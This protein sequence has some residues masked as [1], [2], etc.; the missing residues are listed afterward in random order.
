MFGPSASGKSNLAIRLAQAIDSLRGRLGYPGPGVCQIV[1]CDSVAVYR[2]FDIGSAKPTVIEQQAVPHHLI[3]V[4]EWSQD[5]DAECYRLS[6]YQAMEAI[7]E[8][9]GIPIL[10]G[11]TGL[12]LRAVLGDRFD[13]AVPKNPLLRAQLQACSLKELAERLET[14]NPVRLRQIHANDRVRLMRAI[15][16]ATAPVEERFKEQPRET[17]FPAPSWTIGLELPR[18][19]LHERLAARTRTMLKEG[20][21]EEVSN[22]LSRGVDPGCK[23]MGSIGY[24]QTREMLAGD[25]P[26]GELEGRILAA[27]RQFAK[28]QCTWFKKLPRDITLGCGELP[29]EEQI[30]AG[31]GMI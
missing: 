8:A 9:Q 26:R 4:V 28:R 18:S 12:Y 22:L 11:G 3:D 17:R 29:T 23:P 15:E 16:I 30:Q 5:F 7:W 20:L 31:L 2:G 27:S 25:F 14:L 13:H 1:S 21:V 10:V 19:L 24:R 6:T